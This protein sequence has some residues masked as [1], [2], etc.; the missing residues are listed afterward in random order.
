MIK[1]F[2]PGVVVNR[3]PLVYVLPAQEDWI[4]IPSPAAAPVQRPEDHECY[5]VIAAPGW[6]L[7]LYVDFEHPENCMEFVRLETPPDS[8]PFEY[9]PVG[10]RVQAAPVADWTL[11]GSPKHPLTPALP[12]LPMELGEKREVTLVPFGCTHLRVTYMPVAE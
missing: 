2:E 4:R 3:G 1:L 9:A 6:N 8:R 11:D 12:M 10:I 7:A 5:R